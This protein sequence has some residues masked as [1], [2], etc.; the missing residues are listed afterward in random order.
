M[1]S[2]KPQVKI[3]RGDTV[4]GP[5]T[6]VEVAELLAAGR[7]SESDLVSD[8]GKTWV[9]IQ[10]YITTQ[11]ATTPAAAQSTT[12]K[13]T[14]PST[15]QDTRTQP[16]ASSKADEPGSL[17][18]EDPELVQLRDDDEPESG[19]EDDD[20][21]DEEEDEDDGELPRLAWDYQP[22]STSGPFDSA[23]HKTGLDAALDGL[24]RSEHES[25]P[26]KPKKRKPKRKK[27]NRKR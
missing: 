11:K 22:P 7:I 15:S 5:M 25:P 3:R 23:S 27:R 1:P 19:I 20:R 16:S 2:H 24:A 17:K 14:P 10:H 4:Y 13:P 26:L 12:A 6:M 21:F 8:D 18:I 9:S